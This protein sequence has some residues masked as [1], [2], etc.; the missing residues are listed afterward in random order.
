MDVFFTVVKFF[1]DGGFF[2]YPILFILAIGTAIAIERYVTLTLMV[3][4]NRDGWRKLE[5]GA[6]MR[7]GRPQRRLVAPPLAGE[8]GQRGLGQ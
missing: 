4:K 3:N 1:S 8:A 5:P 7:R 2:M 6:G